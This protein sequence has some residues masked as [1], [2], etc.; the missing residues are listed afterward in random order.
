MD[1]FCH[2]SAG[3]LTLQWK[4]V[5]QRAAVWGEMY[6]SDADGV[7]K[8]V[9]ENTDDG[10]RQQQQDERIFELQRERERNSERAE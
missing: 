7:V 8:L 3:T 10:R 9:H 5:L 4:R 1:V 6:H 2:D